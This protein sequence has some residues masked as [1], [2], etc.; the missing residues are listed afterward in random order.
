MTLNQFELEECRRIFAWGLAEDLGEAGDITSQAVID[1]AARGSAVVSSRRRGVVAGLPVLVEL[2]RHANLGVEVELLANDGPVEEGSPV[3]RLAGSLRG[4]LAL[5]RLALNILGRL[6]GVATLT[7][8]FAQATRGAKA[9]ICDTRKTTPGWRRLEKYAVRVGGGVNHRMGLFDAI[10][11][12]DNHL[13]A[14]G[15]SE[16]S[17][18]RTAVER[19][20]SAFPQTPIEVEVDSLTQLEEALLAGPD[21]VLLDNMEVENLGLAVEMRD[22]RAPGVRLEASGGVTLGTVGAIAAT[23]VD[24][25]SVGALTHSAPA[26]DL[27][28][29]FEPAG[30]AAT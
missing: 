3:A 9:V 10:L 21:S 11:I 6:S 2:A 28:M 4:L 12:K 26:L 1:S 27:G 7:A 14:L 29:D 22:L 19:A 13:A 18:I 23:G 8:Q 5:E 25:I 24:R 17:A 16:D 15:A 30:V 20:R